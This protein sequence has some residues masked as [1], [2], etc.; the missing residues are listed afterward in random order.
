MKEC[1]CIKESIWFKVDSQGCGL[2]SYQLDEIYQFIEETNKSYKIYHP[3][4]GY[5]RFNDIGFK[6]HFIII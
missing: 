3:D 5:L 1:K 6:E 4:R 2:F